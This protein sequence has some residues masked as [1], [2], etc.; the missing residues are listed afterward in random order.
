MLFLTTNRIGKLDPAV[1]SRLHLILHYKRLGAS[2]VL[3]IFRTNIALLKKTEEQQARF[4]GQ[5][6]LFIVESEILQFAAAHCAK[7]PKMKGAWNGRQIRNAFLV[8]SSLARYEASEPGRLQEGSQPQLGA[9]HFRQ[10]EE[11]NAKF[12]RLRKA[13]HRMDETAR[14][15]SFEERDDD[16]EDEEDLAELS[17]QSPLSSRD[18]LANFLQATQTQYSS[19]TQ[20]QHQHQ[21]Q[22]QQQPLFDQGTHAHLSGFA[23]A[24]Q[25]SSPNYN[26][27]QQ[28]WQQPGIGQQPVIG[29]WTMPNPHS[30][31][32]G[33]IVDPRLVFTNP[34]ASNSATLP[35]HFSGRGL[36]TSEEPLRTYHGTD[37][38]T[39]YGSAVRQS[40][41]QVGLEMPYGS[42]TGSSLGT[43]AIP[44]RSAIG[45]G[46]Q[47]STP[48]KER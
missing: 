39:S 48:S 38:A 41:Q 26:Q 28:N 45:D 20:Q 15:L 3:N 19:S 16:F 40:Q 14:A 2:E 1:A 46:Q 24:G 36:Q 4:S 31:S 43:G 30:G 32:Q 35:D 42:A 29:Q 44:S 47:G 37:R 18:L 22:Q 27:R 23:Y 13:I 12:W 11:V 9:K 25:T 33:H 8:A 10:V 17:K 21:H 5:P 7:Y 34:A 6:E